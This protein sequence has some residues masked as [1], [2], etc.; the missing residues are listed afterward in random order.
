MLYKSVNNYELAL[1]EYRDFWK[2]P[3]GM[4]A[5]G[6]STFPDLN[7]YGG[8]VRGAVGKGIGNLEIGYYESADDQS[9]RN[10]MVNNSEMRYL[11]GYSREIGKELTAGVQYYVEQWI[12]AGTK[13]ILPAGR[14]GTKT[15]SL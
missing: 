13:I 1:Y 10:P 15:G 3:G 8:S 2:I 9:G 12:T 4:N 7:V 14:Q 11:A 6:L 5:M